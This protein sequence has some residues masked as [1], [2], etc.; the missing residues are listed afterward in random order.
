ML[1][2]FIVGTIMTGW[3]NTHEETFV[4]A[5]ILISAMIG[6]L[7]LY[8]LTTAARHRIADRKSRWCYAIGMMMT[9]VGCITTGVGL[10]VTFVLGLG[11]NNYWCPLLIL[12]AFAFSLFFGGIAIQERALDYG[13]GE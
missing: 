10:I 5:G 6:I 13:N 2:I 8:C 4:P 12:T 11:K 3:R 1:T 9:G 7:F